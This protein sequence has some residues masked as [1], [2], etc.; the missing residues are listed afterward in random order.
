MIY[1]IDIPNLNI[2]KLNLHVLTV[3]DHARRLLNQGAMKAHVV[4]QPIQT[5]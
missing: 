1:A 5:Q 2:T 4:R 3:I